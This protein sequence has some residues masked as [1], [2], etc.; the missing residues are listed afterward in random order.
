MRR[1][2]R[3]LSD[4]RRRRRPRG[5]A[6][7]RRR[8]QQRQRERRRGR[9]RAVGARRRRRCAAVD[10]RGQRCGEAP[11][12]PR[13]SRAPQGARPHAGEGSLRG[14]G[15]GA[16]SREEAPPPDRARRRGR[17]GGAR[18]GGGGHVA[19]VGAAAR[20]LVVQR[21]RDRPATAAGGTARR[22]GAQGA[23]SA[24]AARAAQGALAPRQQA[25]GTRPRA[26]S[27]VRVCGMC[28]TERAKVRADGVPLCLAASSRKKREKVYG[29]AWRSA[30][31]SAPATRSWRL[32]AATRFHQGER[33]QRLGARLCRRLAQRRRLVPAVQRQ[34]VA[35]AAQQVGACW[36]RRRPP[37]TG[38]WPSSPTSAVSRSR[39]CSR[40][41]SVPQS[42][43]HHSGAASRHCTA[44]AA[45]AATR[46]RSR[47]ARPARQAR[48]SRRALRRV[49]RSSRAPAPPATPRQ[50]GGQV[51]SPRSALTVSAPH[52]V[53]PGRTRAPLP[54]RNDRLPPNVGERTGGAAARCRRCRAAVRRQQASATAAV[55]GR[56]ARSVD[57]CADEPDERRQA[58]A[59]E[60]SLQALRQLHDGRGAGRVAACRGCARRARRWRRSARGRRR[61]TCCD[62]APSSTSRTAATG[63][64]EFRGKSLYRFA[65]GDTSLPLNASRLY[66][67]ADDAWARRAA[68]DTAA[69]T[70]R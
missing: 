50:L 32:S 15:E 35:G 20:A 8:E 58:G 22:A 46:R 27:S 30:T 64:G 65:Y 41:V 25:A 7:E 31:L 23:E 28:R 44:A 52:V 14:R 18:A 12:A 38:R 51:L 60:D 70:R 39:R 45:A 10:A 36:C 37:R 16:D 69:G 42:C 59:R 6:A 9:R 43:V 1:L 57:R 19:H 17:Q 56:R 33:R 13:A 24:L 67:D 48:P 54:P 53:S 34:R 61:P 3:R 68:L 49:R 55:G 2:V 11:Q 63:A 47:R 40:R 21:R 66:D 5:V 26:D 4:R 62:G 29:S